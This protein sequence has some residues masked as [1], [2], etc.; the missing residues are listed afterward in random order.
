MPQELVGIVNPVP[1]KSTARSTIP[2]LSDQAG[3]DS[4]LAVCQGVIGSPDLAGTFSP[5]CC[6]GYTVDASA[7]LGKGSTVAAPAGL[8]ST[9]AVRQGVIGSPD[10]VG[11]F[12]PFG[13]EGSTVALPAGLD[14]MPAAL[15]KASTVAAPNDVVHQGLI[16][17]P[18]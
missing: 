6:E 4:T 3:L 16:G 9:L 18:I 11:T 15:D 5:F 7:G 14:S 13:C 8:D 2:G 17:S 10:L 1:V 12:S